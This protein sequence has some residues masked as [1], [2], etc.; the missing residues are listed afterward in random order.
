MYKVLAVSYTHLSTDI[1]IM[2]VP[3]KIYD[4]DNIVYTYGPA[5][6]ITYAAVSYTHLDVYKRQ[7]G[8][9]GNRLAERILESGNWNKNV[10]RNDK[11]SRKQS[12]DIA[13]GIGFYRG[14][15]CI[16]DR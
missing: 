3:I 12:E 1:L 14:Q 4:S 10:S 5:V 8:K 2:V 11:N 15:M 6:I 9:C 13:D 16:R 7:Q